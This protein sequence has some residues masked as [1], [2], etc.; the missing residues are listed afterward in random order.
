MSTLYK[1]DERFEEIYF[2]RLL[3][4]L[5]YFY[6]K[7]HYVEKTMYQDYY[8]TMD[9]GYKDEFGYIYVMARDDDVINVAGHRLSTSALEDVVMAHPDVVDAAVIGVPDPTK[10]EIPLCLYIMKEGKDLVQ[11]F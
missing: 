8:D 3:V 2:S 4:S 10:G 5:I 9:V 1:A 7:E 11:L 6:Y